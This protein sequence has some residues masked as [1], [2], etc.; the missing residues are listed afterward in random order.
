MQKY[1]A[2]TLVELLMVILILGVIIT[3]TA[4]LLRN[5]LNNDDMN[6]AYLKKALQDVTDATSLAL[7]KSRFQ[8]GDASS[9]DSTEI[10]NKYRLSVAGT[11]INATAADAASWGALGLTA[12]TPGINVGNK[13][14]MYFE[15]NL[16]AADGSNAQ[17]EGFVYYDVNGPKRPNAACADRYKFILYSNR[18][19]LDP[20]TMGACMD[21]TLD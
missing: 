13:S 17:R 7:V 12:G 20:T 8:F 2:F 15:R 11:N 3:L 10:R 1:R 6:R 14:L 18:V 5:L 21:L 19:I 9:D 16:Q 4:P